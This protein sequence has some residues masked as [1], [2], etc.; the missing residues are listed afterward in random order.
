M[1]R[2][3]VSQRRC[4]RRRVSATGLQIERGVHIG[5]VHDLH[6]VAR[7]HVSRDVTANCN[8]TILI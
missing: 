8:H 3:V 2:L 6:H 4:R 7:R 5:R 1:D